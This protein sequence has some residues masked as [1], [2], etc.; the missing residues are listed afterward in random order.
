MSSRTGCD[1]H[2]WI[3]PGVVHQMQLDDPDAVVAG[4]CRQ[5]RAAAAARWRSAQPVGR[6]RPVPEAG[7]DHQTDAQQQDTSGDR[8]G[9]MVVGRSE[10]HG[11]PIVCYVSAVD[12]DEEPRL[13]V[14]SG[15][16]TSFRSTA[17]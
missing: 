16:R 9:G 8:A 7:D 17:K 2:P 3:R 12:T 5:G 6:G 11:S 4:R 13:P 14:V 15:S 10:F 1:G